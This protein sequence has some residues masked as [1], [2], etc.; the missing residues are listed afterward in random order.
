MTYQDRIKALVAFFVMVFLAVS[1]TPRASAPVSLAT[2]PDSAGGCDDGICRGPENAQNCP[3]DCG[4]YGL[5]ALVPF[6]GKCGD[7]ICEGPE[8][9]INCAQDC[10]GAAD[11]LLDRSNVVVEI[12]QS[13]FYDGSED[14][15]WDLELL[16]LST[17]TSFSEIIGADV[18]SNAAHLLFGLVVHIEPNEGYL[19]EH[20]YQVDAQRLRRLAEIIAA[21][22]GRMTVQTQQPFLGMADQLGDPI[23]QDLAAL[24]NEIALHLHEDVYVGSNSDHS[25]IADYVTAMSELK[26][27]IEKVTDIPTA[28]WSGG[29]TYVHMWE[30]AALAGFKTNTNYKNRYTQTSASGFAVVN[31]WRPA[32]AANEE[33]RIAHDPNGLIVYIPSGVYPVHCGKLEAVPRPY[34]YEA[35]DYVTYALRASLQS[36][37]PG[38]VN[39]FY[40]TFHPGDFLEVTDDEEDFA[41]WEAW[42]TQI[43]DPLVSDGRLSWATIAEMAAAFEAWE[44]GR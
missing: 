2:Q 37:T 11:A 8:N 44:A 7:G 10:Q 4:E 18:G 28:T 20:R 26:D 40:T 9:R 43:V 1:C 16:R 32:G 14:E 33:E 21:H 34:G 22:G 25:P 24:G 17:A 39:T 38:M 31:P 13:L 29:N 27:Q 12:D 23:H 35:F 30:A 15:C 36:A 42:L 41:S 19:N 6:Q 5:H 3:Q